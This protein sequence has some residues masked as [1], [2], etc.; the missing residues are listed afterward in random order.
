MRALHTDV[1]AETSKRPKLA[2]WQYFTV[3]RQEHIRSLGLEVSADVSLAIRDACRS[4]A[5]GLGPAT[6]KDALS[7]HRLAECEWAPVGLHLLRDPQDLPVEAPRAD[8]GS[9]AWPVAALSLAVWF[10]ARGI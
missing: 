1:L 2:R 7:F 5:R 6:C 3:A 4:I 10:M 8:P 9:L